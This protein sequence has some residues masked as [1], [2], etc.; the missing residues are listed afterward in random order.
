MQESKGFIHNGEI[1]INVS[2]FDKSNDIDTSST[3]FHEFAHILFAVMKN[4]RNSE[5]RDVY[6][7]AISMVKD[8]SEFEAIASHY[9]DL[10]GSDLYEEAFVNMLE[11]YLK[12][13][14]YITLEGDIKPTLSGFLTANETTFVDTI[15]FLL[16]LDKGYVKS[17]KD[18]QGQTLEDVMTKFGFMLLHNE[19]QINKTTVIDSQKQSTVKQNLYEDNKL[20]M[21]CENE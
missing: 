8:S 6:Y 20:T 18:V 19:I 9:P 4:S 1:Y 11:L 2:K 14:T 3:M 5:I 17:I 7:K 10:V 21:K 16:G 13:K 12:G 15:S